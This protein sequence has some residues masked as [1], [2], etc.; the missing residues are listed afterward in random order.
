M[1]QGEKLL[2]EPSSSSNCKHRP[3]QEVT[4]SRHKNALGQSMNSS[5]GSRQVQVISKK[6]INF[7]P[8]AAH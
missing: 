4:I 8:P 7:G 6:Y 1:N 5:N 3:I 2:L